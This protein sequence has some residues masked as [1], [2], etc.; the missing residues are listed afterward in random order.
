MKFSSAQIFI[1]VRKLVDESYLLPLDT[2]CSSPEAGPGT[3][4]LSHTRI[5]KQ[6]SMEQGICQGAGFELIAD[7]RITVYC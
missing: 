3:I 5:T 4:F 6:V 7:K 2:G 1:L